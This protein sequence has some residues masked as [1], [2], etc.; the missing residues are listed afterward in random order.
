[1][2]FITHNKLLT[3]GVAVAVLALAYYA[4]F[5]S[6]GAG[7]PL[8]ASTAVTPQSQDTLVTLASLNTITLDNSVFK[9]PVF[10]SLTSFGVVI[11]KQNVGRR[12]PF[13][14][15]VGTPTPPAPR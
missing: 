2:Q 13:A 1:M 14:P 12:N 15:T 11:P 6:G 4:F 7:E 8:S 5:M 10:L 3:L 9:D